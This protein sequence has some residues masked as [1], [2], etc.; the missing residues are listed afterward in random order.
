MNLSGTNLQIRGATLL[1]RK[2]CTLD[3]IP[4]YPRQ[5]TYA[6]RCRILGITAF[7]CT[8][9]GPFDNPCLAP[10][11]LPGFSGKS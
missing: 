7:D 8:L 4:T 11:Q 9:S 1:Y 10:S 2:I 5:L 3:G 6:A